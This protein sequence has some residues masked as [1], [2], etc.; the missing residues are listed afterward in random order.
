MNYVRFLFQSQYQI[1]YRKAEASLRYPNGAVLILCTIDDSEYICATSK[2]DPSIDY[3]GQLIKQQ[4]LQDYFFTFSREKRGKENSIAK[5]AYSVMIVP[6]IE[7]TSISL[8]KLMP[9]SMEYFYLEHY[10]S[11]RH[12]FDACCKRYPDC[13]EDTFQIAYCEYG[14]DNVLYLGYTLDRNPDISETESLL[15]RKISFFSKAK[16]EYKYQK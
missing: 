11:I 8:S 16:L 6:P 10:Y 12:I 7:R 5:H 15:G 9:C 1:R 13:R 14:E 4:Y 2:Y 3:S